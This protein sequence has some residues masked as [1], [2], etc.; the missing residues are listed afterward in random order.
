MRSRHKRLPRPRVS[1]TSQNPPDYVF[2]IVAI[3]FVG[4]VTV[5]IAII[6]IFVWLYSFY[7]P[8][9]YVRGFTPDQVKKMMEKI[10]TIK[11]KFPEKMPK[12]DVPASP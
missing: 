11:Q 6:A 3:L 1:A 8:D 2:P 12:A 4:A 7:D 9:I 10:D 5:L